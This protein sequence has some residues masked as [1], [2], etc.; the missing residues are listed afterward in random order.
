MEIYP[1]QEDSVKNVKSYEWSLVEELTESGVC[2]IFGISQTNG[3][4]R[5]E[6]MSRR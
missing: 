6:Q 2:A 3:F 4:E 1:G 5:A